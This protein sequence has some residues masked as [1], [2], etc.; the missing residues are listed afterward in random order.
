MPRAAECSDQA[1][2]TSA[3][4]RCTPEDQESGDACQIHGISEKRKQNHRMGDVRVDQQRKP[5]RHEVIKQ[6][7]DKP[8]RQRDSQGTRASFGDDRGECSQAKEGEQKQ[9]RE[10][11]EPEI[12]AHSFEASVHSNY[13]TRD[14]ETEHNRSRQGTE[15][16]E[17]LAE[18]DLGATDWLRKQHF[19][20]T[21]L[22][23][24]TERAG[25][26]REHWNEV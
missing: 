6:H 11:D 10:P 2:A 25:G 13:E 15:Q 26:Q 18:Q 23:A 1:C 12:F 21:L 9:E 14:S 24:E 17:Y 16:A 7:E 19:C 4:N 5:E 20:R 22:Q 8:H 3:E